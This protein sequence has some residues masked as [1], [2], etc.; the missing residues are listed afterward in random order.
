MEGTVAYAIKAEV[1]D[2]S[3]GVLRFTA[4]KTMYGG[5]H[6]ARGDTLFVFASETQGG[7][8]LVAWGSVAS[9]QAIARQMTGERAAPRVS[10]SVQSLVRG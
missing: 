7:K 3:Q 2:L 1:H 5:K 9:A 10:L 8:G 4:Q 6:I